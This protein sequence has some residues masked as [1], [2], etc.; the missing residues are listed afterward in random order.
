[1]PLQWLAVDLRSGEVLADLPD[2]DMGNGVTHTI[3]QYDST[4]VSFPV[5]GNA[6][7]PVNWLYATRRYGSMI[8]ALDPD[9]FLPQWGGVVTQR[10]RVGGG[11]VQLS[12]STPEAYLGRRYVRDR[13]QYPQVDRIQ[14]GTDLLQ[15]YIVDGAGGRNG[16]P[17]RIEADGLGA[18][19]DGD[20]KDTDDRTIYSVFQDLGFEWSIGLEW[21]HNPE[22][23]TQVCY[24]SERIGAEATALGPGITFDWPGNLASVEIVEDYSEGKGANDILST[25]TGQGSVRPQSDHQSNVPSDMPTIEYRG[26]AGSNIVRRATLNAY[27]QA[28]LASMGPGAIGYSV[29]I[30]QNRPEAF[31]F[32]LGDDIGLDISG[33]EFPE[34][35]TGTFRA[36]GIQL[37][38]TSVTPILAGAAN[39]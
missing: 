4:T 14:I 36:A 34:H 2:L 23:I 30:S 26:S 25:S 37:D 8:V 20:Y 33:P 22:R 18:L 28:V 17:L 10:R 13:L 24:L 3:C 5:A 32:G 15:R 35:P 27:A 9:D 6:T 31:Q 29:T 39:D 7:P 21:Q 12:V 16:L 11:A 38:K 1:M 19:V